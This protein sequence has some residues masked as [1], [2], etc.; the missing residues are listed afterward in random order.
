MITWMQRHKKWLV[1][2]IWIS[3]IAFV[4]AGFVGWGS[5]EYGK[6]GGVVAVVGDREVSVEEYQ[7]EYSNLYEQYS[8]MFGSMFNKELA[9][10]LKLKDTAYRQVLQKNLILSYADSLGLDV[11]NEDIAK[12]LV[13]YN[14]FSK[15]GKFDKDTYVKVLAQ[16][17]MTPKIFE[18]SLKRNI[19]LQKVQIL[20]DLKPSSVEI[21]NISKLVFIEDDISIKI[22]K[23][24]DISVDINQDELKKYWEEN[25]NSY[26]SEVSYDLELKELP[27]VSSNPSDEDIQAHYEK[28]KIDYKFE[29]GKIKSLDEAREQ[30]IKDLDE[31]F[32]R[33]EALKIYLKIKKDEEKLDAKVNYKESLLPFLEDNSKILELTE[34]EIAKP[35]LENNKYV[36]AKLNKK[37]PSQALFFEEAL[38][39]V[40][41]DYE[42]IMKAKK[43]DEL[44]AS[45][46][47]DFQGTEITG[48]TRESIDKI[49]GLE[50][51]DAAKFLN[52]L[53]SATSKEGVV[54]LDGKEVLYKI[55]NSK[56][57]DYNKAKDDVVKGTIIQL[58]EEELMT[59]LMKKL[60]NTFEIQSSNKE[61]E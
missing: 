26:M 23:A 47:K 54:K 27:I 39:L 48:I 60:E 49:P 2:T 37:N 33:T 19:L 10:Q 55:N 35:F 51:K 31:K 25:K 43:L 14:A 56:F 41:K 16:N 6:Q 3:T 34:G 29:D 5:Y 61:K 20:F 8:K 15:D 42:K 57:A 45:Q 18:D 12:E 17:K 30:I 21:E 28:F 1:I 53:F 9:E 38:P 13:K 36:I 32:A 11:T 50:Q 44:S 46:L 7:Q 22:L 4:G 58:Q 52:E 40:T 59:N 24:S